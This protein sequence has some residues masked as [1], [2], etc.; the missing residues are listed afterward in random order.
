M[1]Q[2]LVIRFQEEIIYSKFDDM[3]PVGDCVG[4]YNKLDDIINQEVLVT[5]FQK[6]N[7]HYTYHDIRIKRVL[8]VTAHVKYKGVFGNKIF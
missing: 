6:Q 8:Y 5:W 3:V 1:Y 4:D 7:T 2:V